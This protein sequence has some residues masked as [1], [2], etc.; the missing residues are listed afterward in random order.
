MTSV[1]R[2]RAVWSGF[3]GAPGYTN[4]HFVDLGTD[5]ARNAAG[6]AVKAFFTSLTA[7]LMTGWSVAVV[8]EVTEY[9]VESGALV[10]ATA[11][12]TVPTAQG[13]AAPVVAFVGGSGYSI[14]WNTN[15]IDHGRRLR[16]RTYIVPATACFES[17]GT[18]TAAAITAAQAAAD[19]LIGAVGADFAIWKRIWTK[20]TLDMTGAEI[21]AFKQVQVGGAL[22]P[23]TGRV[24][25]DSAAQLR[26][27][28]T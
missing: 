27:R 25:K 15:L 21:K 13:G 10:S 5:A 19:S 22:A 7:H 6:A 14:Q 20:P 9:N 8:P 4:F 17:D 12:T 2:V 3:S 11:M 24:V 18:L 1:F 16:G 23:V 28:R 26:T